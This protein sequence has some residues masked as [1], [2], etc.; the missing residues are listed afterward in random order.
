MGR[1]TSNY[2]QRL[3]VSTKFQLLSFQHYPQ[4]LR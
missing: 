4:L 1:L 3:S 2:C